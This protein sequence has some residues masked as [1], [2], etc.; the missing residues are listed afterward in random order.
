M[1]RLFFIV[2]YPELEEKVRRVL[3]LHPEKD[4]LDAVVSSMT[5][6]DIPDVPVGDYDAV[7]ARGYTAQKTLSGYQQIPTIQLSISGY[8]LVRAVSECCETFHPK[9]IAVCGFGQQM[10]EART[11]FRYHPP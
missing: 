11:I 1:I 3:S 9:K 5:V 8:D 7:I 4:N 2:P 10:Y 6:E